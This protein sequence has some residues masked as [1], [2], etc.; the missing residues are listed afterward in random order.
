MKKLLK[1]QEKK[2]FLNAVFVR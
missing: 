1:G 2:L